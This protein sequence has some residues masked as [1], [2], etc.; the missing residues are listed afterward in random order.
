MANAI[1]QP[2][3]MLVGVLGLLL[4]STAFEV[5][6]ALPTDNILDSIADTFRQ[7]S[8]QWISV[9]IGH[10]QDL[11]WY[12]A[13]IELV[14]SAVFKAFDGPDFSAFIVMVVR[15]ILTTGF[16]YA[17]ILS[18]M[19]LGPIPAVPG[20]I[21]DSFRMAGN[22]AAVNAGAASGISPSDIMDQGL[23]LASRLGAEAGIGPD[24][25]LMGLLALIIAFIYAVIAAMVMVALI[26]VYLLSNGGIIL[27]GFAASR[28]TRDWAVNYLKH[29]V[30]AGIKLMFMY[31]M[32]GLGYQ[33]M[34]RWVID[35]D[36][37]TMKQSLIV[38]MS[39]VVLVYLIKEI[40]AMVSGMVTGSGGGSAATA[41]GNTAT[42]AAAAAG[43][44]AAAGAL[45]QS[46]A[47][48]A[49]MDAASQTTGGGAVLAEAAKSIAQGG[50]G[51]LGGAFRDAAGAVGDIAKEG[52]KT[53]A[54]AAAGEALKSAMGHSDSK[55]GTAS[56][57]MVDSI[58]ADLPSQQE[59]GGEGENDDKTNTATAADATGG[60][61]SD[62]GGSEPVSRSEA[63]NLGASPDD[64]MDENDARDSHGDKDDR[65]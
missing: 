16:F 5:Q 10:A 1:K 34:A 54:R 4:I 55:F 56:S 51:D 40:P 45:R 61:I 58:R 18:I 3:W 21:L 33:I 42:T 57:R 39:S 24:G 13:L 17:I 19:G 11:F 30:N 47:L 41:L 53:Y 20:M 35:F 32:V 52:S 60:S 59:G 43:G 14:I 2:R 50:S 65:P 63:D 49:A 22:E 9:L 29:L 8:R 7:A 28:Y 62:S 38:V 25:L 27:L 64:S 23:V 44:V 36:D 6:A 31:L 48:G 15:W 26:E 12:L 37:I 46:G